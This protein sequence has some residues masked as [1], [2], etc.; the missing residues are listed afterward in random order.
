[1]EIELWVLLF[2]LGAFVL[3]YI[4]GAVLVWGVYRR[5]LKDWRQFAGDWKRAYYECW[6]SY[7]DRAK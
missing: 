6:K 4:L 2:G 1:M 7:R 3:G 5:A